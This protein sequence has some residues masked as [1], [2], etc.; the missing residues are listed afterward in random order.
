[1]LLAA[2]AAACGRGDDTERPL[3][4]GQ[5]VAEGESSPATPTRA[6]ADAARGEE[7]F[8]S[9][10]CNGCHTVAGVG[11]SVG[12]DLTA[13]GRQPSRDPTRWSTPEAYI[14]ASV[15]EPG[16]YVVPRYTD[17]MP[18][19]EALGLSP[20]DVDDLVAYLMTLRG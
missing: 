15:V 5:V 2:A 12:P 17:D 18:A 3:S 19:A 11:G 7:L 16:A 9:V 6:G 4:A 20:R 14:R 1:M 10:G 8:G 13:V